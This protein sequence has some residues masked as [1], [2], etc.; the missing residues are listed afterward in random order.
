MD[1]DRLLESP[2]ESRAVEYKQWLDLDSPEHC[3]LL[4]KSLIALANFGGGHLVL[5]FKSGK[6]GTLSLCDHEAP[7]DPRARYA[8]ERIQ[9]IVQRY[10]TT[11]FEVACHYI[12]RQGS[13]AVHPVIEVPS[14]IPDVVFPKRGSPDGNRWSR[15]GC[16][17][18]SPA[19]AVRPPSRP[20]TGGASLT[21]CFA[22]RETCMFSFYRQCSSPN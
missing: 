12:A 19:L 2:S 5:G 14:N 22:E 17:R 13:T 11:A 9:Q 15:V 21:T 16:T 4:A 6:H 7:E 20:A 8:P 3:A 18:A 1:F 10:S